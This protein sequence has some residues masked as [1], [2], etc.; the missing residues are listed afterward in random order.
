MSAHEDAQPPFTVEVSYTGVK[1]CYA[2]AINEAQEDHAGYAQLREVIKQMVAEELIELGLDG[3]GFF[4]V[5]LTGFEIQ[6]GSGESDLKRELQRR[7][8]AMH[9]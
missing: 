1:G 3:G 6:S 4:L 5:R 7:F 9:V 2:V 8:C